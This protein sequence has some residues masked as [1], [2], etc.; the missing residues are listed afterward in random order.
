MGGLALSCV[1]IGLYLWISRGRAGSSAG[2][3]LAWVAFVVM[4]SMLAFCLYILWFAD[5]SWMNQQ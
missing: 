1:V 2:R 3:N 5:F 4:V